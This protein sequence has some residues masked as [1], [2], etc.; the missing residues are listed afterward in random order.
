MKRNL[1]FLWGLYALFSGDYL[2]AA[3]IGPNQP[4]DKL[5][6][7][8]VTSHIKWANPYYKGRIKVLVVA[9]TWSQRETVE[10]AQRISIDYQ[11]IMTHSYSEYDTGRDAY[12]VVAPSVVKEVVK[13]KLN[14]D[15]DVV[16]MGKVDWPMLPPEVRLA[17]LKKVFK[18]T[19]LLYIDPPRDEE[20]DKLVGGEKL[21]NDF[22]LS[23]IPFSS[24]PAFRNIS[25]DSLVRLSR[26]GKGKVCVL[27]YNE[28]DKSPYQSLTPF[29]GGY[30]E[31]AFYYDYYHS[32][33]AKII[34]ALA[35]KE[36]D[37]LIPS[38][39]TSGNV[40]NL[41]VDNRTELKRVKIELQCRDRLR[42]EAKSEKEVEINPGLNNIALNLPL[43]KEG[44]HFVDLFLKENEQVINWGSVSM[45]VERSNRIKR[46]L[47]DKPY[48]QEDESV[49]GRI[50]LDSPLTN[51][52]LLVELIDNYNRI[53]SRISPLPS[54]KGLSATA[55]NIISFQFPEKTGPTLS[56][57]MKTRS[58]LFSDEGII[59]ESE[60]EF[61]VRKDDYDMEDFYFLA[62]LP[63]PEK[64]SD[65]EY[66]INRLLFKVLYDC[67]VD[68][69]YEPF[70]YRYTD[71]EL[72][73]KVRYLAKSRLGVIPGAAGFNFCYYPVKD[74]VCTPS[75]ADPNL[76]AGITKSL[77]RQS[78]ILMR[79]SPYGYSLGD[80]N[81][82]SL[83][84]EDI[85]FSPVS[86]EKFREYLKKEY[87][88]LPE[89]NAGWQ[90]DYKDWQ[91]IKP[92]TFKEAKQSD[93][94]PQWVDF[95]LY[96]EDLFAE[97][98]EIS[99]RTIRQSDPQA[100]VG[101]EG[102][103]PYTSFTGYGFF[104]LLNVCGFFGLYNQTGLKEFTRSFAKKGSLLS[105]WYGSYLEPS[106]AEDIMR[107]H[108]WTSLF[109]GINSV[110]WWTSF[111]EVGAGGP[112]A[113]TPS[114]APLLGFKQTMEEVSEIKKGIGKAILSSVPDRGGIVIHYSPVCLHASTLRSE[115]TDLKAS[116]EGFIIALESLGFQYRF[117]ASEEIEDGRLTE[118]RVLI[119]PYSQA[120]SDKEADEI[121]AFV[122][123][124]GL[125][126]ADFSPGTMDKHG[127]MLSTGLL[128]D[129][130]ENSSPGSITE[131]GEGKV[132]YLGSNQNI[133]GVIL[134]FLKENKSKPKIE[135][136][137]VSGEKSGNTEAVFFKNK[138]IEYV[139]LL[140]KTR[141]NQS[142]PV[143]ITFP[144]LA[145]IYDVRSKEYL[146]LGNQI[147]NET[148]ISWRAKLYALVPYKIEK[149]TLVLPKTSFNQGEK[150]SYHIQI[151]TSDK[152]VSPQV[153]RIE[154]TNPKGESV[155]EYSRNIL[156]EEGNYSGQIPLS[157]NEDKGEWRLKVEEIISGEK[158]EKTFV[159][160]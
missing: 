127:K 85:C 43:L 80:E 35:D 38:I 2:L 111:A 14:Q 92:I 54:S 113:L 115:E 147:V 93:R 145:H 5:T 33:L 126:I 91:E 139:G 156:V 64:N 50:F 99:A 133:S 94:F 143:T 83:K 105:N 1:I 44:R 137:A 118:H 134:R 88:T 114:F 150:I 58:T 22:I 82:L 51:E 20:L 9:P 98:Y 86:C 155:L 87:R 159:V 130:F 70:T 123:N 60:E 79:Y 19:G 73:R 95:R 25:T 81:G 90:T 40:I 49:T 48:Y 152:P 102:F 52:R 136:K 151:E 146:G 16:I 100:K 117:I 71:E 129:L 24:L 17:I 67:G 57:L 110:G 8:V 121:K 10:L 108:P 128:S 132:L 21:A 138:G 119:L 68:I 12:M 76:I 18:G 45:Q 106:M 32:L 125:L 135:I 104:R 53:V 89:L 37:C 27:N 77:E 101:S 158:D 63:S 149:L 29:K 56:R 42:V 65:E 141:E 36:P 148:L 124:G 97:L 47:L 55:P 61:L 120:L 72:E 122:R 153:V 103:L 7:E 41:T 142:Q 23:G 107:S 109:E 157:W 66:I 4:Y 31:S 62:S 13:E 46:I 96:M 84:E 3:V 69:G 11:A 78:R 144:F 30:D 112:S 116:W 6:S 26:F 140:P 74:N 34:I 59:S 131:Y 39:S 28:T 15:Y 160:E 154:V 75:P